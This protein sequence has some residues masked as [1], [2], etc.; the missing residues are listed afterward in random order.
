LDGFW[1]E[2]VVYAMAGLPLAV[3]HILGSSTG[4]QE[5]VD[6]RII[7]AAYLAR[8]FHPGSL[9]DAS[10]LFVALFVWPVLVPLAL[11]FLTIRNGGQAKALTGRSRRRQALDQIALYFRHG[12]LPP[13]YYIFE[14]Y[15]DDRRLQA[16]RFVTRF[17][18]KRGFYPLIR[19]PGPLTPLRDKAEFAQHC[20]QHGI[21]AAP[22]LLEVRSGAVIWPLDDDSGSLLQDLFVKPAVG[23]GGKGAMRFIHLGGAEFRDGAGHDY[24]HHALLAHLRAHSR[25]RDLV[26]QPCLRNHPSLADL[27]NG[28]LATVRVLSILDEQGE[29]V[30]TNAVFRMAGHDGA[31]VDNFHAGGF[32]A[33][34][35][36]A[37]G[38]LGP[39]TDLGIL[40]GRGWTDIHPV[41]GAPIR[42]RQLPDWPEALALAKAA[43]R[44]FSDHL[45]IGWDIGLLEDGPCLIEGNAGPDVDLMQ[46]PHQAPMGGG[47][48]S[49]LCAHHILQVSPGLNPE[50]AR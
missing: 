16:D 22:V 17:E 18:T 24:D 20:R 39:A 41:T 46:R 32:A 5:S 3:G 28:A 23:R 38:M 50:P 44:A 40:A 49:R 37:T 36:L 45:L 1:L 47:A 13:W 11:V 43:H 25:H 8:F 35:D 27:A 7:R 31:V 9:R 48:F 14:L 42:G 15:R 10:A 33:A 6:K 34:V 2:S 21:R 19:R 29:P 4:R 30:V 26:V 12:V